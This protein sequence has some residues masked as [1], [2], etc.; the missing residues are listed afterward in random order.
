V[1][2]LHEPLIGRDDIRRRL[3]KACGNDLLPRPFSGTHALVAL[4]IGACR[5]RIGSLAKLIIQFADVP[6]PRRRCSL[7]RFQS[8]KFIGGHQPRIAK[9]QPS[10]MG[11]KQTLGRMSGMVGKRKLRVDTT[12]RLFTENSEATIRDHTDGQ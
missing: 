10:A 9:M 5:Y 2:V 3:E 6:R 7:E 11:R 4:R 8:I 12:P 1:S